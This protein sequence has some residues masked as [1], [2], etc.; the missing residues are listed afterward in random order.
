ML[1]CLPM[2]FSNIHSVLSLTGDSFIFAPAGPTNPSNNSHSK[3]NQANITDSKLAEEEKESSRPTNSNVKVPASP[4]TG[5]ERK[6]TTTP[7]TVV[8]VATGVTGMV[9]AG[10][11]RSPEPPDCC[12]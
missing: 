1:F 3:R 5:S 12:V 9:P 6:K 8:S 2:L 11:S 7:S 10:S 4:H